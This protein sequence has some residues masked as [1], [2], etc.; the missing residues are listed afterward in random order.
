[1]PS[2]ARRQELTH[3]EVAGIGAPRELQ[4]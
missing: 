1:L 3:D 2:R 4:S